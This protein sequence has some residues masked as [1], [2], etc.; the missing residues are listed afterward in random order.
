MRY[1]F[2]II[3]LNRD[4]D[5]YLLYSPQEVRDFVASTGRYNPR[6]GGDWFAYNPLS[7][8]RTGDV[9]EN[10]WILRDDRGRP[11][12]Y[13]VFDLPRKNRKNRKGNFEYRNGAVPGRGHSNP[14]KLNHTAMKNS[15][16]GHRNRNRAR[17]DYDY[18]EFGIPNPYGKP[19]SYEGW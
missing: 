4:G 1:L 7:F 17:A 9:V 5:T 6:V 14:W 18:R 12:D 13:H 16:S 3:A 10:L 11:V 8:Y 15:G 19:I 2:P